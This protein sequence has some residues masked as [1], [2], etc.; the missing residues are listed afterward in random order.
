MLRLLRAALAAAILVATPA[1]AHNGVVHLG[2][3][4]ISL[5][6]TRATL[7][8]APVGGGFLTIENTGTEAD[9]L[10]S[11]TSTVAG[12]TQIHEMAMDGDV[13]KMRQLVDGLEIPAGETAVLAPGGFHIMFMGLK[14]AFVEGETVA[15]TLTFEKA[16]SVEVLLPVEATAADAPT[17][18]H[19]H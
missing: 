1:F 17:A 15:V 16:G 3:I 10:I 13:M 5:P 7:P 12:D 2:P 8:N 4:N 6:F 11:A 19:A 14:Q 9:R 18:E